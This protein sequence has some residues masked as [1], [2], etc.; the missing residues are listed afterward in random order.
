MTVKIDL[1]RDKEYEGFDWLNKAVEPTLFQVNEKFTQ[2]PMETAFSI[3]ELM[4]KAYGGA[5]EKDTLIKMAC[6]AAG[7]DMN[8]NELYTTKVFFEIKAPYNEVFSFKDVPTDKTIL[9]IKTKQT[10]DENDVKTIVAEECYNIIGGIWRKADIGRMNEVLDI[11]GHMEAKRGRSVN[12]KR[13]ELVSAFTNIIK[14]DKWRVRDMDLMIRA[15]TWARRYIDDGNLPA[16]SN[17][18]K[19]KCMTHAGDPIYS[20]QETEI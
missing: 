1:F 10:L 2:L 8:S 18:I 7:V 9:L 12:S 14:E 16:M 5:V 20:I 4:N 15:A 3:D 6:D 13:S 17:L 11:V 19:L